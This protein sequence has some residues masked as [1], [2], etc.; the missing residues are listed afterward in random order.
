MNIELGSQQYLRM[1]QYTLQSIVHKLN[2]TKP[3]LVGGA[4]SLTSTKWEASKKMTMSPTIL[5]L[6]LSLKEV[7]FFAA[8]FFLL[9]RYYSILN[10]KNKQRPPICCVPIFSFLTCQHCLFY[11]SKNNF[12]PF[13]TSFIVVFYAQ[14]R[15]VGLSV[16]RDFFFFFISSAIKYVGTICNGRFTYYFLE[17]TRC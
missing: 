3:L 12:L 17:I 15:I 14:A 11:D 7:S 9:H 10:I 1:K 5:G 2:W 6:C 4:A 8:L 13:K 16:P